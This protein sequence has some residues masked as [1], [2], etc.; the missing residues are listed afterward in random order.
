[1]RCT[2]R[3]IAKPAYPITRAV[4]ALLSRASRI[5]CRARVGALW[6]VVFCCVSLSSQVAAPVDASAQRFADASKALEQGSFQQAIDLFEL[7]ADHGVSNP[8]ASFNRALAYIKRAES[9]RARPG[10]LGRAAAALSEVLLL[11]PDDDD[12]REGLR[13]VREEIGRRRAR[14][15]A[16]QVIV[17][18]SL[19]R[20]ASALLSETTWAAL[21]LLGSLMLTLG[22][23]FRWWLGPAGARLTGGVLATLGTCLLLVA[24]GFAHAARH[25][26]LTSRPAV[27]VVSEAR[28]LDRSGKPLAHRPHRATA[29]VEGEQVFVTEEQSTRAKIE[30]G[31]TQG[32]VNRTQLQILKR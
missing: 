18:P 27:V 26:R 16:E 4:S 11:T 7:M 23:A 29:I 14:E 25:F 2:R 5:V 22:I 32:W 20:T 17:S 1:M 6:W 21:A 12:A 15:G 19:L 13:L 3:A 31:T 8:N 30:W 24:G 28:L 9:N 10:D